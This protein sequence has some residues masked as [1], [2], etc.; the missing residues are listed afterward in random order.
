MVCQ[1][2]L[3]TIKY[4]NGDS[5]RLS[6]DANPGSDTA[7]A[8]RMYAGVTSPE[9]TN[10]STGYY[11]NFLALT[12]PHSL[13]PSGWHASTAGDWQTLLD[14]IGGIDGAAPKLRAKDPF[15][16]ASV[17]D[18]LL[19]NNSAGLG[20]RPSG[21]A[22]FA[23]SANGAGFGTQGNWWIPEEFSPAEGRSFHLPSDSQNPQ[24]ATQP[25]KTGL[26]VRCV[27]D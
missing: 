26:L 12:D 5:I 25:K 1:G 20:L 17:S 21:F 3:R 14:F 18:T 7:A 9:P 8:Y 27:K 11:Y 24:F 15:W 6:T 23:N 19:K 13:C 22:D 4:W 10:A 16:S 2:D